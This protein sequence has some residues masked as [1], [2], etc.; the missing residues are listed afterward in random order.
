MCVMSSGFQ[1][2]DVTNCYP[3]EIDGRTSTSFDRGLA[4]IS[5]YRSCPL[6]DLSENAI[7]HFSI[8]PP[9]KGLVTHALQIRISYAHKGMSANINWLP[10]GFKLFTDFPYFKQITMTTFFFEIV[11]GFVILC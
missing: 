8:V 11:S 5:C 9:A 6:A 2:N 10:R 3:S 4:R 1:T 7:G